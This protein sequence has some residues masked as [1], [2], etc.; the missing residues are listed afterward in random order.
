[1]TG[2]M[3]V[4]QPLSHLDHLTGLDPEKAPEVAGRADSLVA[5]A[6]LEAGYLDRRRSEFTPPPR[7]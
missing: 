2:D 7:F 6:A 4:Y 5:R 1:M 3:A